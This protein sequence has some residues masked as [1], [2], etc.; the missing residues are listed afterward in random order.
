MANEI[1]INDLATPSYTD[2]QRA[3]IDYGETLTVDLNRLS[4]MAEAE[5]KTGFNDWGPEDF[6]PRLDLLC[7]EWNNDKGLTGIGRLGLRNKLL[8]HATS[9][10]LIQNQFNRHPE[11]HDIKIEKPI[12]VAGLPRSGTTHLLN[13]MASDSRLRS[14]P[15]WESYEPVPTPNEALLQNGIDPRYQ[16][17]S[18]TWDM[19]Q[20]M[21]PYLAA[22]H[23]MNPDHIHE[24]LELMGPNFG[25]YNYE[26]LCHSPR[27]RDYYFS[28]DQ[29]YQ[30]E[31]MRDVLKLLIWQQKDTDRPTR[32]VLKCPQHLEQLPIL[33]KV[34]PDATIA[35]THRD[36]VSVIQSSIT[37][38]A[39]GQRLSRKKVM[40][41]QLLN[42]WTDRIQCLLQACTND[43]H[44]LSDAQSIDVPFDQLIQDDIGIVE[45]I[46]TKAGLQMTAQA[47]SEL[48][49]FVDEHKDS[50]GNVIYDLKDQF[51]ADPDKLRERFNFYYDNFSVKR[52]KG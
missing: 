33:N 25:S 19:M 17:C 12:I 34:F 46:Y 50:Y 52:N 3:A 41:D 44:C 45:K 38:L 23:P 13:L 39:Y 27:W 14:L 2:I 7:N 22:M 51:A 49:Q 35:I 32:W 11:I 26:W 8:Q 6:I 15:L 47:R 1:Y 29:T 43:R 36:P 40:T 30:Y 10:L 31:Y 24:E 37:M 48:R 16:R 20:T 4:I 28:E 9:R 5:K 42:Y 21:T 18:D